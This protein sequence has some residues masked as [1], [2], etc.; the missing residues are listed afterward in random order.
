MDPRV[1]EDDGAEDPGY[2]GSYSAASQFIRYL[3][4]PFNCNGAATEL[5][6]AGA[7]PQ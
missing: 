5:A 1:R 7:L 4:H 6:T 2:V 3:L